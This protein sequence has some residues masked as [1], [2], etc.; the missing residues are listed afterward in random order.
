MLGFAANRSLLEESYLEVTKPDFQSVSNVFNQVNIQ[1]HFTLAGLASDWID[2][3]NHSSISPF[4]RYNWVRSLFESTN[5]DITGKA[6]LTSKPFF[7]SGYIGSKLIFVLPLVKEKN[8]LG[9]SVRWLGSELSDYNGPVV[10]NE[11]AHFLGRENFDRII[12]LIST[13]FPAANM[14]Y[15]TR[16]PEFQNE[17]LFHFE[18]GHFWTAEYDSHKLELHRDWKSLLANRRSKKS[19]QRLRSKLN[20]LKKDSKIVFRQVR[21]NLERKILTEKLLTWKSDHLEKIGQRN[22]FGSEQTPSNLRKIIENS[23]ADDGDAS[24]RL[25]GIFKDGQL[26]AGMLAFVDENK[27]YYLVSAYCPKLPSK[28]SV[29]THLLM[30]TMELASRSGLSEFDF[31]IGDEDYK[32]DWSSDRI[33]LHHIAA[34]INS[35][36]QIVCLAQY[37]GMTIKKFVCSQPKLKSKIL[38]T[39]IWLRKLNQKA[40]Q[41]NAS[42]AQSE[43]EILTQRLI[44]VMGKSHNADTL[45]ERIGD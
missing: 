19:R 39:V 15:L 24:L 5:L 44:R 37:T 17:F 29:G 42:A 28:F 1:I 45:S 21:N 10:R 3:E 41:K 9:E 43:T 12:A 27:F 30:K 11:Y 34:P 31:L 40:V 16:N 18:N 2:L 38:S 33:K 8:L 23:I 7:I 20:A 32:F 6:D 25:F 4:Q 13:N 36:G 22:P 26:V 35:K 14:F